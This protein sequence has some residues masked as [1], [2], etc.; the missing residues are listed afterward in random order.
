[1]HYLALLMPILIIS[2]AVAEEAVAKY[3]R[4]GILD[5]NLEIFWQKP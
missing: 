2:R 5:E 1:M 4:T 3:I